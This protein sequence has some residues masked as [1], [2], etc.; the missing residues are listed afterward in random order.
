MIKK[1]SVLKPKLLPF[2]GSQFLSALTFTVG[3]RIA[4]N[5]WAWRCGDWASWAIS[6]AF[7]VKSNLVHRYPT[8]HT[9]HR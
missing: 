9:Q 2:N 7:Q 4:G 6:A 1:M 8:S 3:R 5:V